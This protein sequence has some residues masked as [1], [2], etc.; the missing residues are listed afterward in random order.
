MSIHHRPHLETIVPIARPL[1][2]RLLAGAVAI[3]LTI[4]LTATVAAADTS[5]A[6]ASAVHLDLLGAP[7]PA[8]AT[9][10]NDG[11]QPTQ[12]AGFPN[13]GIALLPSNSIVQAGALGQLA[14]ANA[15]GSSAACA[16]LINPS[17]ALAI[18]PNGTCDAGSFTTGIVLNL[19]GLGSIR[20]G[21]I[22]AEC[23]ADSQGNV[24][25]DANLAN[26]AIYGPTLPII[27]ATKLLDLDLHPAPNT[28]ITLPALPDTE[29][30]L[31]KQVVNPDGSLTVT[32]LTV[33]VLGTGFTIGEVTCGP[34]ALTGE[35]PQL[36]I[37][38]TPLAVG[39][40]ASTVAILGVNRLRRTRPSAPAA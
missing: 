19:L 16:G 38:G 40:A 24:S 10:S 2:R 14:V 3:P 7:I 9:A 27:G 28:G 26:A 22:T 34:N 5:S 4:A 32:A 33:N 11:T 17:A 6:S 25:G 20:A 12:T 30:V 13:G 36:P 15:D 23:T 39:L 21:A 29:I 35:V 31:N 8:P 1:R 37:G 18:A